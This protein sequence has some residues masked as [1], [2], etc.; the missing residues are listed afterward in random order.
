MLVLGVEISRTVEDIVIGGRGL[1]ALDVGVHESQGAVE[2]VNPSTLAD[3]G[4]ICL[5]CR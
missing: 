5:C 2:G 4:A 1:V 3:D